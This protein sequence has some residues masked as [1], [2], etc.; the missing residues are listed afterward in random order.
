MTLG[1]NDFVTPKG[2]DFSEADASTETVSAA[3]TYVAYTGTF[4]PVGK[5]ADVTWNDSNNDF[6]LD[7][8]QTTKMRVQA[9]A[10][11]EPASG[12]DELNLAL[13]DE[14]DNKLAEATAAEATA[15]TPTDYTFDAVV[16]LDP[17][18]DYYLGVVNND[19]TANVTVNTAE[20]S[21]WHP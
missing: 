9:T 10:S 3:G 12:T 1:S 5:L 14:D 20:A 11:M 13:F 21:F 19:T 6:E 7:F 17:A 8:Q 2:E 4:D 18:K 15:T 16:K